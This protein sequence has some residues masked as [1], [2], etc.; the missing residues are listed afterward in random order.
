MELD[1]YGSML[2]V[3]TI[4]PKFRHYVLIRESRITHSATDATARYVKIKILTGQWTGK[5]PN[6]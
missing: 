6:F 5:R 2:L 3:L 1:V 4:C